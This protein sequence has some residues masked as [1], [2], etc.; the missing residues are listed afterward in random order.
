MPSI[1][2][3][4]FFDGVTETVVPGHTRTSPPCER[5]NTAVS[6]PAVTD[7]PEPMRLPASTTAPCPPET[8]TSAGDVVEKLTTD[9]GWKGDFVPAF[10][11]SGGFKRTR[12]RFPA[13]SQV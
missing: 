13:A 4:L 5:C 3:C 2:S 8:G 9:G 6:E 11:S 1:S 7:E 12:S 10:G